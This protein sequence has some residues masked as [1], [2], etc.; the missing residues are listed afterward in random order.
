MTNN[1][2][3]KRIRFAVKINDAA[4]LEMLEKG[5]MT[6]PRS[7]LDSWFLKEE[8]EGYADCG[9]AALSALLDGMI[10]TNRGPRETEPKDASSSPA[11]AEAELDNN[12]VLKKLRIALEL[13]EEDLMAIMKLSGVEL[14]RNELS[15]LFRRKGQ[16][17]YRDCMD[18]FLRNFLAGLARYGRR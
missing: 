15:A 3:L 14:S 18:Q 17:N 16:S 5:G 10:V 9:K 11:M 7:T 8:E 12:I 13:K 4:M 1:D 2:L 6:V